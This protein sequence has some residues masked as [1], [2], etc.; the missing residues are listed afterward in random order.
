MQLFILISDEYPVLVAMCQTELK[1]V[2]K[3]YRWT[4]DYVKFL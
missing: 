2:K 1:L 3:N 4:N